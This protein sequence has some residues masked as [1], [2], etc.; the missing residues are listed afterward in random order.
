MRSFLNLTWVNLKLYVR[1]PVATFFTL[2]FPSLMVLLFGAMY[3]NDPAPLFGGRGSMDVSMPAYTAMILATVAFI[4]VPITLGGY[5]EAGV[6]R[7]YKATALRPFTYILSDV[8]ANLLMTL[9]GMVGLVLVGWLLYRV[10]FEG[11]VLTVIAGVV[12]C[13]LAM[14]A[15]GYLI[16]SVAPNARTAQVVSMVIFYPMLFLSGAGIPLEIMPATIKK[17]A[18]FLPLT[19]VVKLLRGLWFGDSWGE[20]LLETAALGGILVLGAALSARFFRWE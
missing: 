3:G 11:N 19:Y 18:S 6:L 7:R 16:A 15:V 13:G 17:M 4:G 8:V 9:V 14:L 1:E 10:R 2:V 20:H 12:F 5:R